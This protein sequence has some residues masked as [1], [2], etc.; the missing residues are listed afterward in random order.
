MIQ[1][2]DKRGLWRGVFNT[3]AKGALAPII[4]KDRLLAPAMLGY[5]S[6]IRKKYGC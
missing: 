4:L 3:G 5:F 6:A 1:Y 2:V